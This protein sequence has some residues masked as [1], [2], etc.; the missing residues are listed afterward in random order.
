MHRYKLNAFED[1]FVEISPQ[2]AKKLSSKDGSF[3]ILKSPKPLEVV[4]PLVFTMAVP[5][6]DGHRI[7]ERMVMFFEEADMDALEET[8]SIEE[9][10]DLDMVQS[11]GFKSFK[12]WKEEAEDKGIDFLGWGLRRLTKKSAIIF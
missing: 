1:T 12:D 6:E 3:Y 2:Q 8:Q 10:F 11:M 4:Y 7:E 5:V 9:I